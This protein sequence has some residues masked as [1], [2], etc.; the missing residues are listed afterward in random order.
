MKK[1]L[2]ILIC[3]FVFFEVKSKNI[4]TLCVS[5]SGKSSYYLNLNLDNK[6]G[7]MVLVFGDQEV[8]YDVVISEFVNGVVNGVS[9][10]KESRTGQKTGNPFS[11]KYDINNKTFE[12]YNVRGTCR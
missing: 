8:V 3:L 11:F 4:E 1:L 7:F 6:N 5:E 12:E 9:I 2:L 10:F